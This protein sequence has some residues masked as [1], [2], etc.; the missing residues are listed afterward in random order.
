MQPSVL[1]LVFWYCY[2]RGKEVRLEKERRLTEE[3][4]ARLEKEHEAAT[5]SETPTT[6]APEGA[7]MEDV[8]AGMREVQEARR[9]AAEPD[10]APG[11]T[12]PSALSTTVQPAEQTGA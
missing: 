6:T 7:S 1:L 4:V 8:E 5:P 10:E 11:L 2:K 12:S 3:E 9:A